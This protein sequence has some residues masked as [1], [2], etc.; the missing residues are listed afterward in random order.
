MARVKSGLWVQAMLRR[1]DRL[2]MAVAVRRRGDADSGSILLK[3]TYL[4]GTAAILSQVQDGAGNSG[5]M[6]ATGV[7]PAP[8]AKAEAYIARSLDIDPDQWVIEIEDPKRQFS[9][10]EK[11]L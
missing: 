1:L 8:D 2:A 10:D 4:D 9:P 11:M 5:W 3:L 6:R 7:D